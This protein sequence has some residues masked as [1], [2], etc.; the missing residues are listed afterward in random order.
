MFHNN[1]AYSQICYF[2]QSGQGAAIGIIGASVPPIRLHHVNF[3]YNRAQSSQSS[4]ILS[5]GGA[6]TMSQQSNVTAI[7]CLF[8]KN[9]AF[10]GVGDDIASVA[11]ENM[12]ENF[13][14]LHNAHF[15]SASVKELDDSYQDLISVGQK[16]CN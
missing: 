1:S 3:T 8:S 2:S 14:M 5:A 4:T 12:K 10:F 13:L 16:I 7:D 15:E 9:A 6:F 11:G